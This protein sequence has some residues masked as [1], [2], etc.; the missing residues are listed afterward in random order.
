MRSSTACPAEW[1]SGARSSEH[2]HVRLRGLEGHP[3]RGNWILD[4][5][6][7][8]GKETLQPPLL[9]TPPV[10]RV[11]GTFRGLSRPLV[12]EHLPKDV[13]DGTHCAGSARGVGVARAPWIESGGEPSSIAANPNTRPDD[14][15]LGRRATRKPETWVQTKAAGTAWA[16]IDRRA[17]SPPGFVSP[18]FAQAPAHSVSA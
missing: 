8:P 13:L 3:G 5:S 6:P 4:C 2:R 1:T 10:N 15:P 7:I 11:A 16:T 14:C 9:K 17:R 12:L 18:P